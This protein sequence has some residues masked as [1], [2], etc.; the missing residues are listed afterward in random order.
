MKASSRRASRNKTIG[1]FGLTAFALIVLVVILPGIFSVVAGVVMGPVHA[2]REWVTH[3]TD[4]LP[5]YLRDR[6]TLIKEIEA[7]EAEIAT[8]RTSS[9]TISR[10]QNE[11][12]TFRELL[13]AEADERILASVVARPNRLPYDVIQLDRGSEDG[14]VLDAPIF[15]GVD[16]VVGQITHVASDYSFATLVS[17]PGFT[18]TVYIVGP[19]IY[20]PA[21]GIGGG[22]LRVRVPQGIDLSVGDMVV[23]PAIES[24]VYGEIVSIETVPTRPEQFGYVSTGVSL[25]G[26]RFVTI[27]SAPLREQTFEEAQEHID[28]VKGRLFT[29]PVPAG[30]LV[31]PE[32]VGTSTASTSTRASSTP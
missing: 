15:L 16:Q 6:D 14:V 19:N 28:V 5:Q 3:S 24:G 22:I 21:E 26:L 31:E 17:A 12:Q 2:V 30:V 11:N 18:S 8:N 10:L 23:L 9:L 27:G 1:R 32:T 25:Q 7:L 29:V 13:R 4:S 20:T